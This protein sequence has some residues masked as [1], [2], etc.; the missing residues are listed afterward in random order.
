M[1]ATKKHEI[2]RVAQENLYMLKRLNEKTSAYNVDKWKKDYEAS[3]Y[4]KRSH[5]QY[6][7]IDFYKTQ[8]CNSFG[9]MFTGISKNST[10]NDFYTKT[11]YSKYSYS[12]TNNKGNTNKKRKRFED[13]SY[14]DLQFGKKNNSEM[15][16]DKEDKQFKKISEIENQP[17]QQP[18]QEEIHKEEIHKEEINKEEINKEEI[19]KEE[20][21]KEDE[22]KEEKNKEVKNEGENKDKN[23]KNNDEENK[24]EINGEEENK[25]KINK[26]EENK[27]EEKN[28]KEENKNE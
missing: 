12:N 23:K 1:A 18:Q 27:E 6:P 15:G 24:E 16:G 20:I 26:E 10:K 17:E 5:C 4:Y 3:Q 19:H 21:H 25:E 8:K 7:S 2:I 22:Q 14:R 28:E 13:F 9:N 11:Q